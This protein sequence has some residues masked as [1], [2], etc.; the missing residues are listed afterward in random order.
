[1]SRQNYYKVRT[2]RRGREVDEEGVVALV[3]RERAVQPRLGVRKLEVVLA[4]EMKE[5]GIGIGRDRLFALLRRH[6]LLIER[7]RRG[8]RT[9]DARHGFRTYPNRY[10]EMELTG[11]HQAWLSD[12]T[13]VRTEEGFVYASVIS[14]AHSHKIVGHA[15][16]QTLEAT[17][18]V[19]ALEIA[20]RQLPADVRPMHHSDRGIQ[21][22]CRE[23]VQRLE[24]RGIEV[25]MTEE[26]HCYE[27]A[28]AER[29]NGILK[30]EYGLGETFRTK[31][32]ARAAMKQAV[33]LYNTRRP[34]VSLGYRTPEQV[35]R[36]AAEAAA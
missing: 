21:Y 13:Y 34:H 26:D 32:Q 17:G 18:S 14:D 31:A 12:L 8:T 9:T 29:L 22:C 19:R 4:D 16:E 5:M 24:A 11:P 3:K 7:R 1:M 20:L 27:N 2:F 28:Q 30:Q 15:A 33:W 25:S 23:Y 35:H 36:E 6:G 10:R